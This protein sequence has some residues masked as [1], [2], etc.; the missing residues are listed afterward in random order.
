MNKLDLTLNNLQG[1]ICHKKKHQQKIVM[2]LIQ[3]ICPNHIALCAGKQGM[4]S[5]KVG[6]LTPAFEN[7]L[8]TYLHL[9]FQIVTGYFL[10][11]PT[12]IYVCVCACIYIYIYIY[13]CVCV[14]VYVCVSVCACT[15]VSVHVCLSLYVCVCV[16]AHVYVHV[17]LYM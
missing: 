10:S 17:C 2:I 13:M 1:L 4:R 14:C 6:A 15:C 7:Q 16:C 11:D 3:A 5:A 8:C 9:N 12:Y